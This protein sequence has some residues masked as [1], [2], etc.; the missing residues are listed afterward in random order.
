VLG[1]KREYNIWLYLYLVSNLIGV[2]IMLSTGMLVGDVERYVLYSNTVLFISLLIVLLSYF[3]LLKPVFSLMSRIKVR[4]YLNLQTNNRSDSIVGII[5]LLL[6]VG[7]MLFNI[8]E[9]VNIAGAGSKTQSPFSV[10]WIFTPIDTMFLVYYVQ[11]RHTKIF[12]P[13]LLVYFVSNIMRGWSGVFLLVLFLEWCSMYRNRKINIKL[14]VLM[15]VIGT[16]MYPYLLYVKYVFRTIGMTSDGFDSF[17]YIFFDTM[18][19]RSYGEF[20][21]EG[22]SHIIGRFQYTSI[23]VELI[24]YRDQFAEM[25]QNGGFLPFW[26][27][28]LPQLTYRQL[29]GIKAPFNLGVEMTYFFYPHKDVELIGSWNMNPG[30]AAWFIITPHLSLLYILYTMFLCFMSVFLMKQFELKN[31]T[32]DV[33][34]LAWLVYLVPGWINVF[35]LFNYSILFMI[36]IVFVSKKIALIRFKVKTTESFSNMHAQ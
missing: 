31:H 23:I 1:Y 26:Q 22:M 24:H 15:V 14:I 12:A 34:W 17:F 29:L 9:G 21:V 10:I 18:K 20:L 11:F 35:I 5:V 2:I 3:L 25:Y 32:M 33:V 27:D 36:A 4:Q 6:Q 19:S 7:F 13:N 28:G 16:L 8:V 30:Y